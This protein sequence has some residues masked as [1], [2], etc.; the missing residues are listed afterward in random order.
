MIIRTSELPGYFEWIRTHVDKELAGMDKAIIL[1]ESP[2]NLENY[3]FEEFCLPEVERDASRNEEYV[4]GTP[5]L[6]KPLGRIAL[7]VRYP[8]L[9]KPRLEE[10]V[11]RKASTHTYGSFHVVYE[12]GWL[13][14]RSYTMADKESVKRQY[15][16]AIT[17]IKNQITYWN[18]DIDRGNQS[19]REHARERIA[20]IVA[21]VRE[22]E[23]LRESLGKELS[24]TLVSGDKVSSSTIN[25]RIR[26]I[27]EPLVAAPPKPA[28]REFSQEALDAVLWLV[29]SAGR[30]MEQTPLSF[31]RQEE[32]VLRD[33]LL[34]SLNAIL[35]GSA[36]AETF[37]KT[38]KTDIYVQPAGGGTLAI[39]CKIWRGQKMHQE[40]VSQ[41]LRYL[42]W[43]EDFAV[44]ITFCTKGDFSAIQIKARDAEQS[45]P[46]YIGES[47]RVAS[48]SETHTISTHKLPEDSQKRVIL[49]HFLFNLIE[50]PEG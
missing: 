7:T 11:T 50:Q 30:A 21:N 47:W 13:V 15:T 43:R 3:F 41:L 46:T 27:L 32:T 38:G 23:Q 25:L 40:A 10:V 19:L 26:P 20:R 34:A 45:T 6:D 16:S 2:R 39:E 14:V 49:H 8:V 28:K 4:L 24:A 12:P 18:T 17:Y 33:H 9:E 48:D 42:K 31:A 1:K 37:S 44:L 36:T 35:E 5:D 22:Y 29:A